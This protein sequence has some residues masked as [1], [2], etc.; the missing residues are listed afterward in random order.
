MKSEK[1]ILEKIERFKSKE[2]D[3]VDACEENGWSEY[4]TSVIWDSKIA[5]LKWVLGRE[6]D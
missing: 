3:R 6:E 2:L 5:E 4:E 1:E